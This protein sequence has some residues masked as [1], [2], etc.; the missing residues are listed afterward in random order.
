MEQFGVGVY[1]GGYFERADFTR[2][3]LTRATLDGRFHGARFDDA[4]INGA[5]M[6]GAV[7]IDAMHANLRKRG[8]I[9]NGGDFAA[10]IKSGRDF[11]NSL[12]SGAQLQ[13]V[14]L[15]GAKLAAADL[16]SAKFDRAQ[17]NGADLRRAKLYW[18]TALGTR[19]DGADLT[20]AHLDNVRA[21]GASFENAKLI[22]A[23]LCGAHLAA[24]S[25]RN[26]DLTGANLSYADLTGVDLTGAI[27]DDVGLEAAIIED[28]RGLDPAVQRRLRETAGRWKHEL[29]IGVERFL[30]IWSIPLHVALT[31]LAVLLGLIGFRANHT[32]ASFA[33]LTAVNIVATIPLGTRLIFAILGGSPTAQMSVPG[34]WS[35]WFHL[36][37]IMMMGLIALFLVSLGSGGYRIVRYVLM[38]PRNKPGLSLLCALLTSAN[39]LFANYALL[40]MAPDA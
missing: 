22:G 10:A 2:A 1:S 40:M 20:H 33:V 18:G 5:L 36:W 8:A 19:F 28:V 15:V 37:P 25:L 35:L 13:E 21:A 12:L 16:H 17:L 14:N 32:H 11:S 34:L 29:R 23:T 27:L 7:G 24:A 31:P 6:L 26:A 3:D 39:C 30:S 38:R 9:V 4:T